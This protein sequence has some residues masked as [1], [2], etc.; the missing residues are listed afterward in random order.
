[1]M[2]SGTDMM[3]SQLLPCENSANITRQ[4]AINIQCTADPPAAMMACLRSRDI[5][6]IFNATYD[7]YVSSKT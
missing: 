7:I 2:I 1:M 4:I 5:E 6:E 3:V